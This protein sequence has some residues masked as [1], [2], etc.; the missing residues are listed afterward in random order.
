MASNQTP[1][2]FIDLSG[3]RFGRLVVISRGENGHRWRTRWNCLCDC[4]VVCLIKTG[5]LRNKNTISC[6]CWQKENAKDYASTHGMSK[7]QTYKCW[8]EMKYRTKSETFEFAHR[9]IERGIKVCERW[10]NSFT[11][12]YLDMGECPKGM[13]LDRI[14]NDGDYTPDNC[15][16]ATQQTQS[17][18]RG[19]NR[20]IT[21]NGDS[22]TI[23]EWARVSG[24]DDR[25]IWKRLNR[26]WGVEESIFHPKLSKSQK[27][28]P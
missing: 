5:N 24:I 25:T 15:R 18:N 20:I 10:Q 4:G 27:L 17:N 6:G 13:S 3:Q 19:S 22:K 21:F 28:C 14:D 9:Y 23:A 1:S 26:G 7:K 2:N 16:W 11:D 8:A 12:F